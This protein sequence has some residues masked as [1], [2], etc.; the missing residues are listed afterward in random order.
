MKSTIW[1]LLT[2]LLLLQSCIGDDIIQD[3]VDP[4]IRIQNPLDSIAVNT[5]YQFEYMYLNNIGREETV[6]GIWSSSDPTII[7]IDANGLAEALQIGQADISISYNDGVNDLSDIQTVFV[8]QNT[9]P[10]V[11]QGTGTIMTTSTYQLEGDF[12]LSENDSGE[13]IL[14]FADNY[15]ASSSLPGL[16]VYLTNNPSTNTNAHE[17]GEVTVFSGAHNY[18]LGTEI[19]LLDY[20][21]VL[22]YCKPFNVKVGDGMINQ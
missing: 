21:H 13:L 14:S 1:Y 11:Q 10:V 19:G 12:T 3:E 4:V 7:Q 16:Y 9:T 2:L 17:I 18:N 8:R 5:T 15:A 20:S 6:P 22:Y